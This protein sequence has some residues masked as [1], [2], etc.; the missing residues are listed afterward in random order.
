MDI[1]YRRL[2]DGAVIF[3]HRTWKTHIL[4]PAATLIFE[5]LDEVRPADGG[6][7]PRAAA[8]ALLRQDLDVETDTPSTQQLLRMLRRLGVIA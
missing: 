2:G 4:T 3:S 6:P 7:V 5:A 8:L 1:S